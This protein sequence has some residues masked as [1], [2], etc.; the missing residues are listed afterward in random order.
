MV[1]TNQ[2]LLKE[3]N[4][5]RG[6][7]LRCMCTNQH[8]LKEEGNHLRRVLI[9]CNYPIWALNRLQTNIN[10]RLSTNQAQNHPR[11]HWVSDNDYHNIYIAVPYIKGLSKMPILRN[12]YKASR[13]FVYAYIHTHL[14]LLSSRYG[15]CFVKVP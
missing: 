9:R 8:L 7:L 13:S 12:P 4:H 3:E 10:H 14:G 11:R 2:H 6:A 5:I 1:Y 15:G